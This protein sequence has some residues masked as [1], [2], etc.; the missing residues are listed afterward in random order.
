MIPKYE[1]NGKTFTFESLDSRDEIAVAR[2]KCYHIISWVGELKSVSNH[3]CGNAGIHLLLSILKISI[4]KYYLKSG[5]FSEF[6]NRIIRW[7]AGA[8][9]RGASNFG[10]I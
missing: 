5:P 7:W 4:C 8:K 1:I 2:N 10:L 6:P 3:C 9:Q